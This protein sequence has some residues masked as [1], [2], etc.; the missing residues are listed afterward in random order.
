MLQECQSG[1]TP[2][3]QFHGPPPGGRRRKCTELRER[4]SS[5]T[6]FECEYT[7]VLCC[8]A[9]GSVDGITY[10][11]QHNISMLQYFKFPCPARATIINYLI[12]IQ[13]QQL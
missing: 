8:Y 12:A 5:T 6:K 1:H 10:E 2:T 13:P 3:L 9:I 4:L 11:Q 7:A